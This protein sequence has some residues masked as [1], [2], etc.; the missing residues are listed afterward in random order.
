L[1]FTHQIRGVAADRSEET[2]PPVTTSETNGMSG[3]PVTGPAAGQPTVPQRRQPSSV[4][5]VLAEAAEFLEMFAAETGRVTFASRWPVVRDE[6]E[7]TGTWRQ[8]SDELTFG[9]RVAWRHSVRCIGRLRW[10]SLVVRDLRHVTRAE[11]VY[12]EL[13]SHLQVATNSGRIRSTISIFPADTPAGPLVRIWNDQLIRYAGWRLD[14]GE[15]LGDPRYADFTEMLTKLGWQP[16][17]APGRFD[18]LPWVIETA[19]D[20]PHCYDV[21]SSAVLEVPLRHPRYPWFDDLQLRWHALPVIS[22]MRLRIGGVD[23][24]AAPFNGFYLSAE[25]ATRNLADHDRYDQ[26]RPVAER[27]GLDTATDRLWRDK[28]LLVLNETVLTSF[29]N[30]RVSVADHHGESRN[31]LIFAQQEEAAGRRAH[32]DWSWLNP[33]PM[34]PQDPSWGRYYSPGEPNPNFWL[35]PAAAAITQGEAPCLTLRQLH[36][37]DSGPRCPASSG[38]FAGTAGEGHPRWLAGREER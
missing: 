37:L 8:T 28:A 29:D 20:E 17:G 32:G 1:I 4:A 30:H 23:Y 9:A 16:S 35:D 10:R 11:D 14:S 5:D 6:I 31:F 18:V 15:V 24:S 33:Y 13:V 21:P 3:C 26:L 36:Q 12:R 22:N 34:N 27:M 19:E 25:I 7:R 38:P 2:R